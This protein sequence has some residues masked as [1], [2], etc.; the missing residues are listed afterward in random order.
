MNDLVGNWNYP[1]TIR[2]GAGRVGELADA[3]RGLGMTRPLLITDPGLAE[4]PMVRDAIAANDADGLPTGLFSD[5]QP[6]PVSANV[7][8]GVKA[9]RD[10]G[11]DGVI[12]FGGGSGLDAAKAVAFMSG[13]SRPIWDFEDIGDW[14]TRADADGIAPIVG[15]PTTAGTGSE[16]GRAAVVTD[17][18]THTKKIIFHPKMLPGIVIADPALTTGLPPHITAATGIDALTHSLEALCATGYHPMAEGIAL[19][20]LRLI[21]NWLPTACRDG[22]NI[23]ARAHMLIAS[24]MGATAFQKGLG[25]IHALSHPVSALYDTHHGLTNAVFTPYVMVY[26]RPAIEQRM[27]RLA[28]L[29]DLPRPSFTA[30]LDWVL[31]LREELGIPHKADGLGIETERLDELAAKAEVDPPNASNPVPAT[32][33]DLRGIYEAAL[34]GRL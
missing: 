17:E 13:Q 10:G 27:T 8:T 5:I 1:T 14:W 2:F 9:F 15:V 18:S 12:A 28:R 30:V 25:A 3:C 19:E 11:H 29:L 16:V 34:E 23:E 32:A 20:S 33:A 21:K 7:E 4:L 6:N 24:S 22:G 26:N 31:E